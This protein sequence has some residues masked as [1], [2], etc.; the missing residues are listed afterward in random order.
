MP[1][2]ALVFYPSPPAY[3]FNKNPLTKFPWV[4]DFL[5]GSG[6]GRTTGK[7]NSNL[8]LSASGTQIIANP[9]T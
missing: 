5:I 1:L 3:V 6:H 2:F 8:D 7:A 9:Y 4:F